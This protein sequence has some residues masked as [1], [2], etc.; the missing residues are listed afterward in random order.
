ML[1]EEMSFLLNYSL[2][3]CNAS[4]FMSRVLIS[5]VHLLS[6]APDVAESLS[7]KNVTNGMPAC[8]CVCY[9]QPNLRININILQ[10]CFFLCNPFLCATQLLL[11]GL[12]SQIIQHEISALPGCIL[13]KVKAL[14]LKPSK[15][16]Y[17]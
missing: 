7:S 13:K 3:H 1:E 10:K 12:R 5:R 15:I 9:S 17:L 16:L 8:V 14:N 2:H 6:T 11:S 4:A